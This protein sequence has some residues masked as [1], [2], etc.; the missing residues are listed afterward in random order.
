M[1]ADEVTSRAWSLASLSVAPA[2]YQAK[3]GQLKRFSELW[4]ERQGQN[5]ALAVSNVPHSLDG[6]LLQCGGGQHLEG[7]ELGL[8]VRGACADRLRRNPKPQKLSTVLK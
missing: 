3:G 5:L 1:V 2:R 6:G 8:A 7:V 4:P